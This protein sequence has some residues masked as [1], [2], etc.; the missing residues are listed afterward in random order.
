MCALVY[1]NKRDAKLNGILCTKIRNLNTKIMS[2]IP[3]IIH[4][5]MECMQQGKTREEL[6]NREPTSHKL[7]SHTAVLKMT[8]SEK[9]FCNP[10]LTAKQNVLELLFFVSRRQ[11][12][13]DSVLKLL[14]I[15]L[16][17]YSKETNIGKEKNTGNIY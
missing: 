7:H 15:Q 12:E 9:N 8:E 3:S 14:L 1:V 13:F 4:L 6:K 11:V 17:F 5:T 2:K 16:Y 10:S